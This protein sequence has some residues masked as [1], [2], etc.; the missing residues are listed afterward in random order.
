MLQSYVRLHRLPLLGKYA[1]FIKSPRHLHSK[2][3]DSDYMAGLKVLLMGASLETK[4][5]GVSALA[6]GAMQSFCASNPSGSITLLDY[7]KKDK[8]YSLTL[9]DCAARVQLLSIRFSWKFFLKNNIAYLIGLAWLAK[10]LPRKRYGRALIENNLVLKQIEK[11]DFITALSGGDSFSDIYGMRR[12]LYGALPQILVITMEKPLVL[13][14]QTVGPF[15]STF[16]K[17]ISRFILSRA[18]LVYMRDHDSMEDVLVCLGTS[19]RKDR[20]RFGYDMGFALQPTEPKEGQYSGRKEAMG[21]PLIGLN[22]SGLLYRGGYSGDNMFGL[23]IDYPR[24]VEDVIDIFIE[25]KNAS[26]ILVPHVF[27]DDENGESDIRACKSI[28]E[29]LQCRH[30]NRLFLVE[31]NYD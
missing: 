3:G 7:A 16:A 28:Y 19:V 10:L 31:G 25:K 21:R 14:P 4:N 6:V 11:A 29:K 13:L 8:I 5:M 17:T 23:Q 20:F 26:V 15:T 30:R 22:V 24:L 1:F 12:L 2:Q 9:Q 27:G 18:A